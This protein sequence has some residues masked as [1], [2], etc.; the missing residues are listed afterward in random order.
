MCMGGGI[1]KLQIICP[2]PSTLFIK[3]RQGSYFCLVDGVRLKGILQTHTTAL[4]KN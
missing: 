4:S 2:K 1:G 3:L